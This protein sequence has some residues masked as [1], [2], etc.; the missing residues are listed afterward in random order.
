MKRY[1]L[2]IFDCDGTLVDSEPVSNQVVADMMNDLGIEMTKEKSIE[3]FAGKKFADID[4]YVNERV[5]TDIEFNF[6]K[7]FR[8]QSKIAFEKYLTVIP[9]AE[10]FIKSLTI[11]YC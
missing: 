2:V 8:K 11:P 10:S 6:E 9:G 7:E 3:L 5:Q 4:K 1:G